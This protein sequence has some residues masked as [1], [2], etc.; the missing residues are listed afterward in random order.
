MYFIKKVTITKLWGSRDIDFTLHK[1]VNI[2]T[3]RNGTGKTTL[4]NL[5]AATLSL[6]IGYL[7]NIIF[8]SIKITFYPTVK[9]TTPSIELIRR[10]SEDGYQEILCQIKGKQTQE[11]FSLT[12]WDEK[13]YESY[14]SRN[15]FISQRRILWS[16]K[17]FP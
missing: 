17:K 14:R 13:I 8:K 11:G 9:N 16:Q 4:I 7:K 15:E 2:L 10:E 12:V 3:G 1:D 5:I 6:D